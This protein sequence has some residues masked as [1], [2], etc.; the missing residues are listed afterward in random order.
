M[1]NLSRALLL[2]LLLVGGCHIQ[3]HTQRLLH[4]HG[5]PRG[6]CRP[7]DVYIDEDKRGMTDVYACV[8]TVPEWKV[9][10]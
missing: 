6:G 8:R 10:K 5:A 2:L 4:G 7:G 9:V 3:R 1:P